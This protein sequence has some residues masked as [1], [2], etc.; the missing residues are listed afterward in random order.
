MSTT[1]V[2]TAA[3]LEHQ[4]SADT[5]VLKAARHYDR[6]FEQPWG[7]WA[8]AVEARTLL[9]AVRPRRDIR[10]LDAGCGPGRF[11]SMLA[12]EGAAVV[13]LDSDRGMLAI[14]ARR[15][16]GACTRGTIEHVPVRSA[17]VDVAVAVTVL[18]FVSDPGAAVA[19]LARVTRPGGRIVV[20]A[21]NPRSPWGL[22]HRRRLSSGEWCTARFLT[23]RQLRRLGAR[24]GT[25]TLRS[26]LFAPGW[27]PGLKSLGAALEATG[28]LA[29]GLGAFQ[30]L[31]IEKRS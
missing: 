13:G 27:F 31:T 21:L 8:F 9:R 23:R 24:H 15:L 4:A 3:R 2:A 6:W 30:V 25:T 10:V 16:P 11:A 20:A 18:E 12:A 26:A 29:P 7:R 28:R 5:G 14:A 1:R 22:A 17:G 19:E